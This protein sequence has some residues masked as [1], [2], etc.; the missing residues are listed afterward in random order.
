MR[1]EI[2]TSVGFDDPELQRL[3]AAFKCELTRPAGGSLVADGLRIA[4]IVHVL[5]RYSSAAGHPLLRRPVKSLGV[6]TL[7]QL[8]D[9]IAEHLGDDIA[10]DDLARQIGLSRFHFARAFRASAGISPYRYILTR[11]LERARTM[12]AH[13]R[14]MPS[15]IAS[16]TGFADQSHLTRAIKSRYGVTPA[17]L[18]RKE[19]DSSRP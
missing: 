4:F 2:R 14:S 19:Q 1:P 8:D 13:S 7:R 10:L 16:A 15:E 5:E 11:R 9:Y 3:A 17:V 18:R 12:L 6:Q